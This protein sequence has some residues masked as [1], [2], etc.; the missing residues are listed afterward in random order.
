LRCESRGIVIQENAMT[1]RQFIGKTTAAPRHGSEPAARTTSPRKAAP[2]YMAD[3]SPRQAAQRRQLAQCE[4]RAAPAPRNAL[5]EPLRAGMHALSGVD[6][7]QVRVHYNSS[8]PAQLQA[9]AYAQGNEIHLGPGQEQ[10]LAHE[11]W[12]LVQQRQGRVKP[13]S[14]AAGVAINDDTGLE[15]EA[16]QMGA[17][18]AQMK[19]LPH[20]TTARPFADSPRQATQRK[21]MDRLQPPA[22]GPVA[23]L[24]KGDGKK[25][26]D[27]PKPQVSAKEARKRR[28][29]SADDRAANNAA[30]YSRDSVKSQEKHLTVKEV[31]EINKNI[32]GH[33][34]QPGGN[35]Q[36]AATTKSQA[37]A[38]QATDKKIAEKKAQ[39]QARKN[40]QT[41]E[42]RKNFHDDK[43]DRGGAGGGLGILVG[44][45]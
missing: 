21:A 37:E 30:K 29:Q 42:W 34:S 16:D 10:H 9:A 35:K 6:L 43:K 44:A 2:G 40:K 13:T 31:K 45:T 22:G 39:E 14:Q 26:N 11:A 8:R 20:A 41:E 27:K 18:A 17:R 5:P 33:G 36:N 7:E 3:D 28:Q 25:N 12:H 4:G 32:K 23:Q 38:K 19:P 1:L 15:R 24:G